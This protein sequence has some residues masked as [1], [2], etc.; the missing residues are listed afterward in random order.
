MESNYELKKLILNAIYHYADDIK[1]EDCD[2]YNFYWMKNYT[3]IFWFLTFQTK[4]WLVQ[5]YCVLDPIKWMD[6]LD[7]I[8]ELDT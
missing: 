5:N 3:E 2:F 6:L 8:M 1:I 7:F 4:L